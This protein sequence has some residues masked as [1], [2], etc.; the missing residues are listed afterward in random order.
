MELLHIVV[1]RASQG[2]AAV[3][4]RPGADAAWDGVW[5]CDRQRT[6]LAGVQVVGSGMLRLERHVDIEAGSDEE[7]L[8]RWSRT[9]GALGPR[10]VGKLRRAAVTACR[11]PATAGRLAHWGAQSTRRGNCAA[12]LRW[13]KNSSK[14][15]SKFDVWSSA[16]SRNTTRPLATRR[17]N[18]GRAKHAV[19]LAATTPPSFGQR[20]Q[21]VLRRSPVITREVVQP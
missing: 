17:L 4:L 2:V 3:V 7:A 6:P 14:P 18:Q 10:V 15:S 11:I 12:P 13:S 20:R 21:Q 19:L 1:P 8:R 16:S 5:S 9:I